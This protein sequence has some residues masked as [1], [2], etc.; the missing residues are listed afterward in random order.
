MDHT[1]LLESQ[2]IYFIS[3]NS[4]VYYDIALQY[5]SVTVYYTIITIVSEIAMHYGELWLTAWYEY[6]MPMPIFYPPYFN[7]FMGGA[8]L[9][10]SHPLG[11]NFRELRKNQ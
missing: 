9:Y 2:M 11:G 5:K 7:P 1:I 10:V 6:A 8:H 4:Q 3:L